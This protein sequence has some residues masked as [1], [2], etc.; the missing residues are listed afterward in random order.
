M[1]S[2]TSKKGEIK[3]Y[4]EIENK[5]WIEYSNIC[6]AKIQNILGN[7]ICNIN[8]KPCKIQTCFLKIA[9]R[10]IRNYEL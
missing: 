8:N 6:Q 9:A 5:K 10:D 3:P 4:I 2:F 7:T 1:H